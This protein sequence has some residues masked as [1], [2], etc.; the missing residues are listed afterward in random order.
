[1]SIAALARYTWRDFL[2]D[3]V[4]SSGVNEPVKSEIRT[5]LGMID[6]ALTLIALA[7][8][9]DV[10]FATKALM[11]ADLAH[12]A[13]TLAIV[14][15]DATAANKGIYYK[16]GASGAGSWVN[17]GLTLSSADIAEIL[18]RLD[19][20]EA[21]IVDHETRLDALELAEDGENDPWAYVITGDFGDRII[22]AVNHDGE[23]IYELT[24]TGYNITLPALST[25]TTDMVRSSA[26]AYVITTDDETTPIDVNDEG[27]LITGISADGKFIADILRL[28]TADKVRVF[29]DMER[30]VL[31]AIGGTS[32]GTDLS[33]NA[34]GRIWKDCSQVEG[35]AQAIYEDADGVEHLV[36][37]GAD[38]TLWLDGKV[39]VYRGLG[40]SNS[41]ATGGAGLLYPYLNPAPTTLGMIEV[42]GAVQ[43]V[44]LGTHAGGGTTA[45]PEVEAADLAG[46]IPLVTA[47]SA[48]NKH[49]T[50]AIEGF[51]MREITRARA[52]CGG[53]SPSAVV[54]AMGQ[55]AEDIAALSPGGSSNDYENGEVVTE[56]LQGHYEDEGVGTVHEV[57]L[58]RQGESDTGNADLGADHEALRA[59][60]ETM[61]QGVTGQP[62]PLTMIAMQPSSFFSSHDGVRDMLRQHIASVDGAGHYILSNP[63][64]ADEWES[65]SSLPYL[66]HTSLGH[67]RAGWM[68]SIVWER[69]RRYGFDVDA[70]GW[71]VMRIVDWE[72]TSSTVLKLWWTWEIS[73]D[74]T[75]VTTL[76]NRGLGLGSLT[77]TDISTSGKLMTITSSN[78]NASL[79][80]VDVALSGHSDPRTALT[81]PRSTI[82]GPV[83]DTDPYGFPFRPRAVHQRFPLA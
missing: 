76:T 42:T 71:D 32:W 75:W 2:T 52:Q 30:G 19:D 83:L 28:L 16:T 74:T 63:T 37:V 79:T 68:A 3:G 80:Q 22:E 44:R 82:C 14:Y 57:V 40:Q 69:Y 1:M 8:A 35:R 81:I 61:I 27:W 12:A 54:V 18:S 20:A 38:G 50:T 70:G 10:K 34:V 21:T 9:I 31:R 73:N 13:D 7:D 17:T 59:A 4:P 51:A 36:T 53:W 48:S 56:W 24:S 60:N 67:F 41:I 55:G 58:M 43:D 11:D 78:S 77:V 66:H 62:Q 47:P 33:T 23:V 65:Y 49:G 45:D 6:T 26:W 46:I 25:L 5:I 29:L 64:Y 39:H 15:A 72:K